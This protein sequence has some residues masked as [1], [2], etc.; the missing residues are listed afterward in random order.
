MRQTC[1][2]K[3]YGETLMDMNWSAFDRASTWI[4][5]HP[6]RDYI[7]FREMELWAPGIVV[8]VVVYE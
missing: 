6:Y 4:A 2:F 3:G 7:T 1:F 8:A 5:E